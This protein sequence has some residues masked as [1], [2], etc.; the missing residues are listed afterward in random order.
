MVLISVNG[1]AKGSS[2]RNYFM[3]DTVYF[4]SCRIRC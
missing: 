2:W 4:S 1:K 3:G